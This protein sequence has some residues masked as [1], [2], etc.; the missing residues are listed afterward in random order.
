MEATLLG[1]VGSDFTTEFLWNDVSSQFRLK[2]LKRRIVIEVIGL[3]GGSGNN[4]D[5][6]LTMGFAGNGVN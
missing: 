6:N 4:S 5:E 2:D 1:K 3:N